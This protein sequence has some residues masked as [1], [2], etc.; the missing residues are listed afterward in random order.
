MTK[1]KT[2]A[3]FDQ[4]EDEIHLNDRLMD[5]SGATAQKAPEKFLFL[6]SDVVAD[7]DNPHPIG[8]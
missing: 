3:R 4:A 6:C 8:S 2:T 5:R 7:A 1:Q